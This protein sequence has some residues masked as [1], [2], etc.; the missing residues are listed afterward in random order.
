[1]RNLP[2]EVI[3]GV[4][5]KIQAKSMGNEISTILWVS[6]PTVPLTEDNFLEKQTVAT[7]GFTSAAV[8]IDRPQK[9]KGAS[10]IYLA[11]IQNGVAKVW[12]ADPKDEISTH[13]WTDTGFLEAAE[14]VAIA[15]DGTM[16]KDS[17]G[18][19]QFVTKHTPWVFW[20]SDGALYAYN[21]YAN[22]VTITLAENNCTRVSAVRAM[23]SEVGSFDFGLTV[24]FLLNGVIYYRQYIDGEW[25]DAELVNFGPS[26]I[27]WVDIAAY[28]TQD[29][30][31]ALQ[32]MSSGGT[33]YELFT[34]Y[35]G[36]GKQNTEHLEIR[37]VT[38]QGELTAIEYKNLLN[39][40]HLEISGVWRNDSLYGGLYSAGTPHFTS[41]HNISVGVED[42][43]EEL[44]EDWGKVVLVN[45]DVHLNPVSVA[46]NAT[47]FQ[48]TDSR[49]RTFV[50]AQAEIIGT[51]GLTL[52]LTFA[53]FNN[54]YGACVVSYTPG[55]V[56]TMAENAAAG[57]S[58]SF[59]P[60][61]LV[62]STA[63][64]PEAVSAWPIKPDGTQVAVKFTEVITSGTD[65]L[66]GWDVQMSEYSYVPGGSIVQK[67]RTITQIAPYMGTEVTFNLSSAS[68]S[69]TQLSNGQIILEVIE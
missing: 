31:I 15:F 51:D 57:M 45:L 53:D 43:N 58:V 66:T 32:V 60:T 39:R 11:G 2:S 29:Y 28:R 24:F 69:D 25:K 52:K 64:A 56:V 22:G 21:L 8:A 50:A 16:P 5:N 48:L 19:S 62:P 68:L 37:N 3:N 63:P 49:S 67:S 47:N 10:R 13:I 35:M 54:A 17:R 61:G 20:V 42:E 65:V 23:W 55:S 18:G 7:G 41:A 9:D 59:T 34:Q 6:R 26:G 38:S 46:E 30:R 14:D 4:Q 44:V 1:M 12:V 40:E 36:I 33:V 27:T